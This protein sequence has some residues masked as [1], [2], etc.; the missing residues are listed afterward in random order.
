MGTGSR[1]S[2]TRERRNMPVPEFLLWQKQAPAQGYFC[3]FGKFLKNTC[4]EER[5]QT[6]ASK[7]QT[8]VSF[9][10]FFR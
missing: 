9:Y 5:L 8:T 3:E 10:S 1:L 4:F 7:K 6:A 2:K